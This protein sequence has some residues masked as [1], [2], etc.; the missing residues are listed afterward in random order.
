MKVDL[1]LGGPLGL[2]VLDQVD[3][4]DIGMVHTFAPE[5]ASLAEKLNIS[6]SLGIKR[7]GDIGFCMHYPELFRP[8]TVNAY[9]TIYNIHPS[10]LPCN[11][12]Y[13]PAFWC[14]W[15]NEPT[16]C[17]L[18]IIDEG[19]DTGPIVAQRKVAKYDWDTGGTLHRRVSDAEKGLFLEYWPRIASGG[20]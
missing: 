8:G 2:W 10:L 3:A 15:N 4:G 5:I 18:H 13:Y 9:K 7:R 11:R 20:R 6:V 1:F 14:L 17:T 19:I 12:S 16:G